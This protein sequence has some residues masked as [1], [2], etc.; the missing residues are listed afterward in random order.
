MNKLQKTMIIP[1]ALMLL[2]N[3]VFA[4]VL[5]P[6]A[7]ENMETAFVSSFAGGIVLAGTFGAGAAG[8]ALAN[9]AIVLGISLAANSLSSTTDSEQNLKIV[10]EVLNKEAAIYQ[11]NGEMGLALGAGVKALLNEN[12][13][14]SESEAVDNLVKAIN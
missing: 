11:I 8:L 13:E 4:G 12:A 10:K 9:S 14:L 2:S 5:T 6:K 7:E 1:L 3:T